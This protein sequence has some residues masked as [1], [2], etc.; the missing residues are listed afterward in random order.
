MQII[1][2]NGTRTLEP[3]EV[4]ALE[5]AQREH[6]DA[7]GIIRQYSTAKAERIFRELLINSVDVPEDDAVRMVALYPDWQAGRDYSQGNRVRYMDSLYTVLQSHTSQPDWT[8]DAASS[9]FAKVLAGQAGTEI[10]EWTQPDSTNPYAKG[11]KVTHGGKTW[12]SLVDS[13][14]WEPSADVPTLWQEV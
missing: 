12:E 11:D 3:Y 5:A 6:D 9:L 13:N 1:D 2:E 8:P 4:E 14:V 10:G 7:N